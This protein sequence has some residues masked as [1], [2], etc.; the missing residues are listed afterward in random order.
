MAETIESFQGK[1]AKLCRNFNCCHP[2]NGPARY[3]PLFEFGVRVS[4]E[5]YIRLHA[6]RYSHRMCT[7]DFCLNR[8]VNGSHGEGRRGS[9]RLFSN[10]GRG[11]GFRC[12]VSREI[13]LGFYAKCNRFSLPE[14]GYHLLMSSSR[15][16]G[17]CK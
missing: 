1:G 6:I 16:S 2:Q 3:A 9:A 7:S 15:Q 13:Y 12:V 10:R 4:L 14:I 17:M 11:A 5:S 8:R